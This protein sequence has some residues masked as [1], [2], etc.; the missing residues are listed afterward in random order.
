MLIYY[1]KPLKYNKDYVFSSE[2]DS[3]YNNSLINAGLIKIPKGSKIALDGI[4]IQKEQKKQIL[5][6][7]ISGV[8]VQQ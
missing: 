8:Q 2:P 5:N 1:V 4:N 3:N 6:G 7:N